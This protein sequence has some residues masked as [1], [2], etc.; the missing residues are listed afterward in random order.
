VP[1]KDTETVVRISENIGQRRVSRLALLSGRR[2]EVPVPIRET[3]TRQEGS[4]LVRSDAQD[5]REA[6]TDADRRNT[7]HAPPSSAPQGRCRRRLVF[8]RAHEAE[9]AEL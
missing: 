8:R 3:S 2:R 5:D 4:S 7:Q 9:N 6:Q 1:L